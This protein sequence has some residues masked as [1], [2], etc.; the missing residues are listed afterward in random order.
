MPAD[1][2]ASAA[3][4]ADGR[5]PTPPPTVYGRRRSAAGA[6]QESHKAYIPKGVAAGPLVHMENVKF[7]LSRP[8][9]YVTRER[10]S[11]AI[12]QLVIGGVLHVV[13]LATAVI[14]DR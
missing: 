10:P 11:C 9:G 4:A 1:G 2:P 5:R 8:L 13:R 6:G 7:Y 12:L 3:D 14:A